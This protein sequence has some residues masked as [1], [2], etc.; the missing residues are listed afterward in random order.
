MF[1]Q[2]A[3]TAMGTKFAPALHVLVLVI[4]KKLFDFHD[5]YPYILH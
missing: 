5:Y 2:L 3:G 4:E 1:L